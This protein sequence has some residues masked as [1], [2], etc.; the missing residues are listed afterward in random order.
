MFNANGVEGTTESSLMSRFI[1][2]SSFGCARGALVLLVELGGA[3]DWADG[4]Y[5]FAEG[6][7][8]DA[9][10]GCGEEFG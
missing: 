8:C 9:H 10:G 2:E 5:R 7:G 4:I 1:L 3:C 6:E